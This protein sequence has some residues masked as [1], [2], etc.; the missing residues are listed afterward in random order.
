MALVAQVSHPE[1]VTLSGHFPGASRE[2]ADVTE[3]A[4]RLKAPRVSVAVPT[5]NRR[6]LVQQALVAIARQ[7]GVAF[8]VVVVDDGSTDGSAETVVA[9]AGRLGLAGRLVTLG[10]NRGPATARNA[11][12]L[13]ARG[14]FIA[15]TDSDCLP[16]AGWLAAGLAAFGPEIGIV[17][18][19]TQAPPGVRPP[20]FSHFI[21]TQGLDGSFSTSNVFYR[22]QAVVEAGGFDPAC[23]DWEDRELG[24]RVLEMGWQDAFCPEA[25]VYHQ[26][27]PQTPLQWMRWPTQLGNLPR[28]V[29][30]YPSARRYM[31]GR[32]WVNP[33][34]AALTAALAGMALAPK[35]RPAALLAVPYVASFPLRHGFRGKWPLAKAALHLWWDLSGLC[36]AAAGSIKNRTVLL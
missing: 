11:A 6:A 18:G 36:S 16:T 33:S 21:E 19:C 2:I 26:V 20:F 8:E 13:S 28:W 9:A 34:H 27:I 35:Y 3:F 30:R 24:C 4:R 12:L 17:Q 22:R 10:R 15:F 31:F 23:R 5:Y 32:Y 7:Q 14:E 1:P 25:L 29:A